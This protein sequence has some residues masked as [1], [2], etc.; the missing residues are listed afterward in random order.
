MHNK[1]PVLAQ[2]DGLSESAWEDVG[3]CEQ[4]VLVRHRPRQPR[5]HGLRPPSAQ[6]PPNAPPASRPLYSGQEALKLSP[7]AAPNP[8]SSSN[9]RDKGTEHQPLNP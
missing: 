9:R 6:S 1:A 4:A 5:K 8:C 3:L 2:E 7:R